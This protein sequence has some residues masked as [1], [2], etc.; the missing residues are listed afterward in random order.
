MLNDI[1]NND[2]YYN[3]ND[4]QDWYMKSF[5][6][7]DKFYVYCYSW[8]KKTGSLNVID[9]STGEILTNHKIKN[10]DDISVGYDNYDFCIEYE[11][12]IYGLDI[13]TMERTFFRC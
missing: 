13:E 1:I 2:D 3:M 5:V 4:Y 6:N 7:E 8:S 9:T 11:D 10:A 12:D